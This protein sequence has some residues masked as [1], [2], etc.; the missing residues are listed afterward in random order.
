MFTAP[1]VKKTTKELSQELGELLTAP[2]YKR[3]KAKTHP[4][5]TFGIVLD[6]C[7]SKAALIWDELRKREMDGQSGMAGLHWHSME[8]LLQVTG[9]SEKDIMEASLA[10]IVHGYAKAAPN[11]QWIKAV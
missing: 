9:Y 11:G 2:C 1:K 3:R 7:G 8:T 5:Q 6:K 10:L 4:K